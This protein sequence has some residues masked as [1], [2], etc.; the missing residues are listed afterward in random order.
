MIVDFCAAGANV[1]IGIVLDDLQLSRS[2]GAIYA[3]LREILSKRQWVEAVAHVAGG[4]GTTADGVA[5]R[6]CRVLPTTL[7]LRGCGCA[8]RPLSTLQLSLALGPRC[9]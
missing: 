8:L 2:I 5:P 1:S 9:I 3:I 7:R 4:A 6:A